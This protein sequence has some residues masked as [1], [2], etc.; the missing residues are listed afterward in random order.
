MAACIISNDCSN[1]SLWTP[2]P[3]PYKLGRLTYY[4]LPQWK[5]VIPP[6][7]IEPSSSSHHFLLWGFSPPPSLQRRIGVGA[8]VC[9]SMCA[10]VCTSMCACVCTS[11]WKPVDALHL[12][13]WN[14][15]SHWPLHSLPGPAGQQVLETLSSCLHMP[16]TGI[17]GT[18]YDARLSV[19]KWVQIQVLVGSTSQ[20]FSLAAAVSLWDT[21]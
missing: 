10:C 14:R 4:H 17:S 5:L 21:A 12:I 1:Y 18:C 8:C 20:A 3:S 16:S 11:M 6:F 2:T 15:V 9:T 7:C 19:G 13:P